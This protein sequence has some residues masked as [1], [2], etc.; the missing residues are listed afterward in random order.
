[1]MTKVFSACPQGVEAVLITVE[2]DARPGKHAINIVGLPDASTRESKDRLL[3]A[4]T[5]SK[6]ALDESVI[7]INLS[8]ADLRKEGNAYDLPMAIG[9]LASKGIIS[10]EN[11]KGIMFL[12]EMA[13]DGALKP[14]RSALACAECASQSGIKRV[15]LPKGNGRE[16]SLIQDIEV[17]EAESFSEVVAYLRGNHQLLPPEPEPIN[18]A[19]KNAADFS[20]V[21]GQFQAK[22]AME[23]AA[24]GQHNLLLFGP[25]GSGKSMLSKRLPSILPPLSEEEFIEVL[26]VYSSSGKSQMAMEN[27]RT[28]PF[29][30]PHHTASPIALI[31]GGTFPRPGEVTLAHK[32]VLFLDEFPEFP[33][34]VLEVLRQPLEDRS[35]TISR[36]TNQMTFPADFLM[37][38][39]MNPCPCGWRGDR[40]RQCDCSPER[41]NAY[42]SKISG[43]LLDRI[44]MHVEVS[45]VS[46]RSI[47][48][49]PP[50][51]PSEAIRNRVLKVRQMQEKRFQS[52]MITN[53]N[54]SPK[55]IQTFC[56]LGDSEADYLEDTV[57]RLG[58][59]SRVHSKI[60]KVAR[61]I[62]DLAEAENITN[63]HLREAIDYRQMDR[64]PK[65]GYLQESEV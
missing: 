22:R 16:A 11:L 37:V 6:Y 28:R 46:L 63:V 30:A 41:V 47:R 3:P 52:N 18:L 42:K 25:P 34:M 59:S 65:I 14:V 53:G 23:I 20:E 8:P 56:K 1:M 12:G 15:I 44:D 17:L 51:E 9:I 57:E 45:T 60:L 7:V 48:K 13:L 61:T 58:C 38:A 32:G 21:K 36:A 40:K 43:P 55:Q 4:I 10:Q 29:R 64:K 54:M 62:A 24:A 19:T 33:R 27:W 35:V 50:S 26:R 5:N 31:G 49:L 2:T 39:A